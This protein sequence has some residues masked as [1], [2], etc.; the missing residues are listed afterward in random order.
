MI[1]IQYQLISISASLLASS[2]LQSINYVD[3]KVLECTG[4]VFPLSQVN[5][6]IEHS[7]CNG[8]AKTCLRLLLR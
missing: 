3:N 1:V 4:A 7:A 6:E 5:E 2:S 8:H